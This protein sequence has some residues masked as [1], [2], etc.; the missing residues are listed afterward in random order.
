MARKPQTQ[1]ADQAA[2]P[3]AAAAQDQP[4]ARATAPVA[5]TST[6]GRAGATSA[7]EGSGEADAAPQSIGS[8]DSVSTSVGGE[9]ASSGAAS[10]DTPSEHQQPDPAAPAVEAAASAEAAAGGDAALLLDLVGDGSGERLAVL[11]AATELLFVGAD[12]EPELLLGLPLMVEIH[13]GHV[14][15]SIVI[16]SVREILGLPDA[17]DDDAWNALPEGKRTAALAMAVNMMRAAA[18]GALHITD[19]FAPLPEGL[20]EITAKSSDGQP[21]TRCGISWGDRFQTET[22]TQEVHDR[23][24]ADPHL[25]VKD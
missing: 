12:N 6:D 9:A 15:R 7:A 19:L 23:L 1:A 13:Q 20:V 2:D 5:E 21:F 10:D 16:A 24:V 8:T 11:P 3:A 4:A 25:T 18:I 17:S 14:P 22:V